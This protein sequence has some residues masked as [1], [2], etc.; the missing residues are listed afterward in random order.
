MSSADRNIC[1]P[2]IFEVFLYYS[3]VSE[4]LPQHSYVSKA[5]LPLHFRCVQCYEW[6]LHVSRRLSWTADAA[7]ALV[8]I[9]DCEPHPPSYTDQNIWWKDELAELVN[10]DIKVCV[11]C[12][13]STVLCSMLRNQVIDSQVHLS[14]EVLQT[15]VTIYCL[16]EN[17]YL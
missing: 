11:P 8:L 9:G 4:V 16:C 7:K 10:Q 3:F 12:L 5:N 15:V 2:D 6:A 1:Q 13:A 17:M 14:L